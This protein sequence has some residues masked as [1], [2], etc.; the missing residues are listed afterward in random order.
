MK[1]IIPT[2]SKKNI[3][4]DNKNFGWLNQY[5]WYITTNNAGNSYA[6]TTYKSQ[7][8]YM[9]RLILGLEPGDRKCTDHINN[10][11]LD[12]QEHNL[13]IC[14]YKENEANSQSKGGISKYKG[15]CLMPGRKKCWMAKINNNYIG[16]FDNEKDAALAYDVAA[17]ELFGEFAKTNF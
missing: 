10:N 14:N 3:L 15:V 12:N 4:V 6:Y 5:R 11:G 17:K 1:K 2:N 16:Y 7:C 9:H 8:L 13:R